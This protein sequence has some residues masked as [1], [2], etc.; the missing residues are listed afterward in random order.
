MF[1][2]PRNPD[3][4]VRTRRDEENTPGF[5]GMLYSAGHGISDMLGG[6][7]PGHGPGGAHDDRYA[8]PEPEPEPE[9]WQPPTNPDGSIRTRADEEA[10]PGLTGVM[11]RAAHGV[12]D[13]FDWLLD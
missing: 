7:W 6:Y 4:S 9:R 5:M 13:V 12:S 3:G 10:E 2:V 11:Y 1:E 8:E